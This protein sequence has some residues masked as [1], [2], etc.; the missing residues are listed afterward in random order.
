MPTWS[1][2]SG[3]TKKSPHG[4][5]EGG[6]DSPQQLQLQL[7]AAELWR[8]DL[9]AWGPPAPI[10]QQHRKDLSDLLLS[11]VGCPQSLS[12]DH[13]TASGIEADHQGQGPAPGTGI[14]GLEQTPLGFEEGGFRPHQPCGEGV[15]WNHLDSQLPAVNIEVRPGQLGATSRLFLRLHLQNLAFL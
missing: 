13:R 15:P 3:S 1:A 6:P 5:P 12:C 2:E 14:L 8:G 7:L 9:T 11:W 4:L 10:P